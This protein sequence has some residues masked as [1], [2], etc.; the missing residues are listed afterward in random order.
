M[1]FNS[2]ISNSL[3]SKF[4]TVSLALGLTL[5]A[6]PS[7]AK[8]ELS[9]YS[10]SRVMQANEMAQNDDLTGA[11]KVLSDIDTTRQYD[12][13]IIARMLGVFYW[14]NGQSSKAIEQ[15]NIAV[16]SGL[17]DDGQRWS[18]E[19]M[20]ADLLLSEQR[21]REALTHYQNLLSYS[22]VFSTVNKD[23]SDKQLH[24]STSD[25][26]LRIAQSHYQLE[27]WASSIKAVDNLHKYTRNPTVST[28]SIKLGSQLQ[29]SQW[30]NAIPTVE[31]IIKLD[32]KEIKWWRQ[33]VSLQ[34]KLGQEKQALSS[35]V[36]IEQQRL[37]LN[38]QERY[39]IAQLYAK[40]GMPEKA[41]RQ[42]ST[43]DEADT[44]TKLLKQQASYWQQAKEWNK[45][46]QAWLKLAKLE[47]EYYWNAAQIMLQEG[48]YERALKTLKK[49]D[50][51]AEQ[52]ALAKTRAFYKLERLDD[53]LYQAKRANDID[54]SNQAN[55]WIQ[56]LTQL[57]QMR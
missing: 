14:Q 33:L 54:P 6:I 31:E 50:G 34:L 39:L 13:A 19:K 25:V 40:H 8:N 16:K 15:I 11:I 42:I 37:G 43:L 52:V 44:D 12:Q 18:T 28:L 57:R 22:Q 5:T 41:A 10:A 23:E 24:Q 20:L 30:K 49:V 53:A 32:T 3:V 4:A 48:Q 1:K 51:K 9:R 17:L 2:L 21:Y 47:T 38:D 46:T 55:N 7:Y 56:Y 26:K 27:D 35:L 36:L 45:A 29:L